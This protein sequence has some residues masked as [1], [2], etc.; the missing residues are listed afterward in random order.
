MP[1]IKIAVGGAHST[2]KTTFLQRLLEAIGKKGLSCSVVGDLAGK[3]PLPILR[4]H[5]VESTLWIVTTGIAAEIAAAHKSKV[6]LV[7]RSVLDAWAYLQATGNSRALKSS[8]TALTTLENA[9]RNWPPTYTLLYQTIID[10]QLPIENN[11]GRDLDP[12]YRTEVAR[13][14]GLAYTHFAAQSR[15]LSATNSDA[16]IKVA[17]ER[18]ATS[19]S[20]TQ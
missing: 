7:D 17:L 20:S 6:V 5:T 13:Q 18:L 9:I 10:E 1:S 14:I 3:C 4:E 19:M 11:K 12:K 8:P 15:S 2:G 16:E